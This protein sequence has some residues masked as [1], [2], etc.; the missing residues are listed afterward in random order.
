MQYIHVIEKQN[1]ELLSAWRV[2]Y[3]IQGATA[4]PVRLIDEIFQRCC[5]LIWKNTD[6]KLYDPCI[7]SWYMLTVLWFLHYEKIGA[8]VWSDVDATILSV[9]KKNLSLLTSV[10]LQSRMDEIQH[11]IAQF[12]KDS[13]RDALG[14]AKKLLS[15]VNQQY[16]TIHTHTFVSSISEIKKEISDQDFDIIIF[17][18][19]YGMVTQ[20]SESLDMENV[21][22]SL[23]KNLTANGILVIVTDKKSIKIKQ[24]NLYTKVSFF[25]HGKRRITFLK[26]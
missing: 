13:H 25:N 26:K 19:P 6:I 4:F 23:W 9:A 8:L 7:G 16:H 21:C 11:M 10:W 17:D 18:A 3:S 2:L 14:D 1:Y 22:L 5:T 12:G 15:R 24:S 20:W